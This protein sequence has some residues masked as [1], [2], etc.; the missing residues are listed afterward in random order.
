[1]KEGRLDR[2]VFAKLTPHTRWGVIGRLR[3]AG[4]PLAEGLEEPPV[5]YDYYL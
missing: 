2:E 1:M 4:S 3:A 5:E